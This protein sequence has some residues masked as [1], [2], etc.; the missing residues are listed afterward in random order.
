[1][2][3][4]NAINEIFKG[5]TGDNQA[6]IKYL[7]EQMD[8]HKDDENST[9]IIRALGRKIFELLPDEAKAELNQ[10][11]GNEVDT[12]N[13][14][15]EE[16]KFQLNQHDPI[17]AEE[18]LKSA[19]D[20]IPLEFKEDEEC[21]YFCFED[22]LETAIFI[23]SEKYEKNVRKATYDFAHIYFM[24]AYSL[25]ENHKIDEAENALKT[26]LKWNP[27][28]TTVMGELSEVYKMKK[29]YK[30]YLYWSKRIIQ[31]ASS[32]KELARGYRNIAYYYCDIEE[33]E[34]SAAIYYFS[35]YFEENK[36][37]TSEL[38]YIAERLGKLPEAPEAEYIE[39]LFNQEDIQYGAS[40]FVIGA[41]YQIAQACLENN[42]TQQAIYYLFVVY[43]LTHD[44]KIRDLIEKLKSRLDENDSDKADTEA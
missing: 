11:I 4:Q 9:E 7:K 19:I 42:D 13:S 20:S 8:K 33:Y 41:A 24:Y 31:Y 39:K 29:D 37:V 30:N 15:V 17:K 35:R 6:D 14:A 18:L 36:Q 44:D 16:A 3:F 5:L 34:K 2:G 25:I 38:F 43:D 26:A 28:S 1:M 12:I 10:I 23:I 40:D 32:S 22:A 21:G 27:V